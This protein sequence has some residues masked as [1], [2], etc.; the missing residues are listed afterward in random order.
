LLN[1]DR[2][3]LWPVAVG[4]Y[5]SATAQ[6][7]LS[8]LICSRFD[9]AQLLL[10]SASLSGLKDGIAAQCDHDCLVGCQ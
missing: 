2:S 7:E 9:I 3:N 1:Q 6:D 5:D 10:Y 4:D 8:D